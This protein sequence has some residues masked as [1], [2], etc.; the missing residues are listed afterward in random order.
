MIRRIACPLL[1]AAVTFIFFSPALIFG[2]VFFFRDLFFLHRPL[3]EYWV[4]LVR[5]GAAPFLNPALSLGP[6]ILSNPNNAVFYPGNL[7]YL[8]LPFDIAWNLSL[9]GHVFWGATGLWWLARRLGCSERAALGGALAF[10]FAGPLVSAL[11]YYNLL[12]TGSWIPWVLG[13][14]LVASKRGGWWCALAGAA[15]A[16]QALAGEASLAAATW[17]LLALLWTVGIARPGDRAAQL[18]RAAAAGII[19]LSL[20]AIQTLPALL[21]LPHTT[22]A[23]GLAFGQ[24]A[25][26]WSLH[27][28]RLIELLAPHFHG[29]P[30][31]LLSGEF[32]GGSLSDAGIPLFG[33][34]YMGWLPLALFPLAWRRRWGRPA[35]AVLAGALL[36]SLGHHLPLYRLLYEWIPPFR[37]IRYPEKLLVFASLGLATAFAIGLDELRARLAPRWPLLLAGGGI[38]ALG[39]AFFLMPQQE[40]LTAAQRHAQALSTLQSAA[41]GFASLLALG[42]SRRSGTHRLALGLMPAIVLLD[43]SCFTWDIA[44]TRPASEESAV[45]QLVAALP[46]VTEAPLFHAGEDQID[47]YFSGG[48]DPFLTMRDALH[49]LTGLQWG[50]RY[51]ACEDIDRMAWIRSAERRELLRSDPSSH[52][53]LRLMREMG[54]ARVVSLSPLHAEGLAE[55]SVLHTPGGPSIRVYALSPPLRPPVAWEDERGD[56]SPGGLRTPRM[57]EIKPHVYRVHLDPGGAGAIVVALNALPGWRAWCEEDARPLAIHA[58]REGLIRVAV[59]ERSRSVLLAYRPP[60]LIAG[61]AISA[62]GLALLGVTLSRRPSRDD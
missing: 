32:W 2:R 24:S 43:L 60:G 29:N 34:I 42:L 17:L 51:A 1:I 56:A 50:A 28:A 15:L 38:L 39:M 59:P 9:A 8:I 33:K 30:A 12:V 3:R 61:A 18:R 52:A 48:R 5:S 37:F 45:P 22:R 55:E 11:N 62:L 47:L 20:S 26:W 57:E 4:G 14:S 49:P 27:P 7:L 40:T 16:A 10:G 58:T 19:A 25:A 13:F 6:P 46:A 35:I 21:W 41:L 44:K 23:T 36:L 53:V 54:V 31:G